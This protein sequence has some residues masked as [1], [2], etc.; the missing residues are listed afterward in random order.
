MYGK[1][2]FDH[3]PLY[4]EILLSN[5]PFNGNLLEES[6]HESGTN[7]VVKWDNMSDAD[8]KTYDNAL[9]FL[10]SGR[11]SEALSCS[12]KTCSEPGHLNELSDLNVFLIECMHEASSQFKCK[13]KS[14]RNHPGWKNFCKT[15][16]E[17]VLVH[18]FRWKELV[19]PRFG[20]E[21]VLM[22]NTL[23]DFMNTMKFV[24][25]H[26]LGI[27]KANLIEAFRSR[28]KSNIWKTL[29]KMTLKE[30]QKFVNIDNLETE[31]IAE[32]FAAQYKEVLDNQN[33]QKCEIPIIERS[34]ETYR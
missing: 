8:R 12:D 4:L 22:K 18:F 11:I 25:A 3:S 7:E 30:K 10:V 16:Y 14:S 1:T 20:E 24:R 17:A 15:R 31:N 19:C 9:N 33:S 26:E 13:S 28:A 5:G 34:T 6:N 2:L 21:F 32:C 27:R 23:T 29:K